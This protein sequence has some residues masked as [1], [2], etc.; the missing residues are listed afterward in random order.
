MQNIKKYLAELFLNNFGILV[1]IWAQQF[2][3]HHQ[4]IKNEKLEAL[5]RDYKK[6]SGFIH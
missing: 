2:K 3:K 1:A 5:T 4:Y 6:G